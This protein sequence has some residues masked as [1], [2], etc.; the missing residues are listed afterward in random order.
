[1]RLISQV[2]ISNDIDDTVKK[3]E[4]LQEKERF[5]HIIKE[6]TFLVEDAK[7]AIEKA[8]MASEETTVIILGAKTFSP[9]GQNKLLKVI[10][11]PP[12]KKEFIL[13]TPSKATILDTIRS[14]LPISVISQDKEEEVLD[15]D[16]KQLSLATVYDFVQTHKRTDAKAMKLI[17][18][19]IGKEA[20]R[21]QKYDLDEKTLSLFSNAYIALDMGSPPQFILNTLLLKLL[22]RKKR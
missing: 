2:I 20:I 15:L 1:M 21:S 10:E 12:P 19:S 3:L 13:I 8:Y 5:V 14:R 17:I 9:V 6:D 11:E 18:E 4:A 16:I 22:A 7:L